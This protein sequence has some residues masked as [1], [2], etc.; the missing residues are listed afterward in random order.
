MEQAIVE[1][2]QTLREQLYY[3][4]QRRLIE[5]LYPMAWLHQDRTHITYLSNLKGLQLNNPFKFSLKDVKLH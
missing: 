3:D 2:N 4:I 5:E 1:T